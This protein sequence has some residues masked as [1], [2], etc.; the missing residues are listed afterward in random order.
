MEDFSYK[1][2][3]Y[4]SSVVVNGISMAG[5]RAHFRGM[6]LLNEEL[7]KPFIGVINTHNEMHPGHGETFTLTSEGGTNLVCSV[8]GRNV[9]IDY[10]TA[11]HPGSAAFPPNAEVALGPVEGT[12]NGIIVIDG[13]IPHPQLNL[14]EEPIYLDVKDGM[15]VAVRGG[16]EAD[17]LRKILADYHG[18]HPGCFG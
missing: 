12:A 7:S 3:R 9:V 18:F 5:P 14:I 13:S 4:R 11:I 16:R 17:I 1:D 6:G 8:K 15:I 2:D 10:G